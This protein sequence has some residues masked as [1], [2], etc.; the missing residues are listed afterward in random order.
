M[1]AEDKKVTVDELDE[2]DDIFDEVLDAFSSS[3]SSKLPPL[4][5]PSAS[6]SSNSSSTNNP[7]SFQNT[8]AEVDPSSEID[9]E[10]A[11]QLASDMEEFVSR[12]EGLWSSVD[13]ESCN[14][15]EGVDSSSSNTGNNGRSSDPKA[16]SFQDKIN[17]TLN[18]LQNSSDRVDAEI[19]E[20]SADEIMDRV[21]KQ[22]EGLGEN[23]NMEEML[24]SGMDNMLEFL[25]ETLATKDYLYEPMKEFAQKYPK[26]LEENKG[27]VSEEDYQ[28]YEKQ[29]EYIKKIIAKYEAPDFDEN[30][31]KQNK[32]IVSLMQELQ[33]FGQPPTEILNEL[34]PGIELDEQGMP[35]LSIDSC[36]QM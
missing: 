31:E 7:L 27:L 30:N 23:G 22:L 35:N 34:A 36:K 24:G 16:N 15:A 33:D 13:E 12:L 11:A 20:K 3:Q 2:S 14:G 17:Q 1:A 8:G 32:E 5:D 6:S 19:T 26:W 29:S 9:D 28:R 21:I 25:M 4:S 18:N 10:Y